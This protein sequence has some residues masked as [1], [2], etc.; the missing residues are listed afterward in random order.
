[1]KA[2][3]F[4]YESPASI[5]E[6]LDAL[7]RAGEDG[8]VLAGGQSLVPLLAFRLARPAVLVDI[9]RLDSG[10]S[11]IRADGD[12]L[13]VGALVRQRTAERAGL[14]LLSD[15]L[16]LVAHPAVRNR[17]T[18]VGS[19]CHA[20]PAAE[21]CAGA[22]VL[23]ATLELRSSRGTREVSVE[24]LLV[25]PYTTSL[26]PDELAIAM[27]LRPAAGWRWKVLE[28][29]RRAFDFAITG[30]AAGLSPDG[31]V[32]RVGVFGAAPHCYRVDGPPS[33]LPRLASERAEPTSD[34]HAEAGYRRHLVGVLTR[35]AL[36]SLTGRGVPRPRLTEWTIQGAS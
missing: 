3:P 24:D 19:I 25:G 15:A 22:L 31:T 36:D 33:E 17:G 9:N 20:D 30:V 16:R 32:G 14:P 6:A 10:L 12:Q 23:D 28:V 18:V 27:R 8:K 35:R 1:V 11:E 21:L 2:A 5:E 29:S 34:I 13:V 7:A 4:D 26:A